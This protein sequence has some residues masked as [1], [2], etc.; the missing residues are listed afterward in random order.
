MASHNSFDALS[1]RLHIKFPFQA[2]P[3][4]DVVEETLRLQ[5]FQKPNA[6]LPKRQG[7]IAV[8][9]NLTQWRLT[10]S[11]ELCAAAFAGLDGIRTLFGAALL[12]QAGKQFALRM[13]GFCHV[14]S[15]S[16]ST[17]A[18]S[19]SPWRL[20]CQGGGSYFIG[21]L[22]FHGAGGRKPDD[23]RVKEVTQR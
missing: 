22:Q 5:F 18:N 1:K 19:K 13:V 4:Q 21:V 14:F 12:K 23:R 8:A 7:Q 3:R 6:F 2:D 20:T 17:L 15:L 16:A 11:G 10:A 9:R